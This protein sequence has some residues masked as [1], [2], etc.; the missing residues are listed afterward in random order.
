MNFRYWL[1]TG[2]FEQVEIKRTIPKGSGQSKDFKTKK[3]FV[4][5]I[6][7]S[8]TEGTYDYQIG[9]LFWVWIYLLTVN[10][11][12]LYV[13]DELKNF[14]SKYGKVV[15]HQII[16]DHETNR[17]R[18]FGF[19]I[20]DSEEVVDDMLSKGSMIDM[21]GAQVS[22]LSKHQRNKNVKQIHF[23]GGLWFMFAS[24]FT[25]VFTFYPVKW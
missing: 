15:E 8:V 17:S 3:I 13:S 25:N 7:S 4:G 20:F 1:L 14:F 23:N 19:V 12:Y 21:A 2:Y 24:S 5:G 10:T 9:D 22:L 6:P 16:R 11:C 18:G